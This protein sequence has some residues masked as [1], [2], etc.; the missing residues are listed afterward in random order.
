MFCWSSRHRLC[1]MRIGWLERNYNEPKYELRRMTKRRLRAH[2]RVGKRGD[3]KMDYHRWRH[4]C[5]AG[6]LGEW[7]VYKFGRR[8]QSRNT[9][10]SKG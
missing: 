2:T 1:P 5:A 4:T 6:K 3:S 7:P 10:P 9:K 8:R